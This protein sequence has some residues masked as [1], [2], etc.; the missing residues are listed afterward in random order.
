MSKDGA[1]VDVVELLG[2]ERQR[3]LQ[4]VGGEGGKG[5][6]VLAP[7]DQFGVEVGAVEGGVGAGVNLPQE[8][9]AAAAEVQNGREAGRRAPR[10]AKHP[11]HVIHD[12]A[13]RVEVDGGPAARD[14]GK[15]EAGRR[16]RIPI[17]RFVTVRHLPQYHRRRGRAQVVVEVL[18]RIK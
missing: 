10:L 11:H 9:P 14:D 8:P 2:L 6:V 12:A 15:D 18:G 17:R 1:G 7:A 4:A 5:Q 3:R 16:R 13:A